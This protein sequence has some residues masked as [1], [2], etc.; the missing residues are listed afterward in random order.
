MVNYFEMKLAF[1]K[2]FGRKSTSFKHAISDLTD[3]AGY[4]LYKRKFSL[5]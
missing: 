2:S 3:F 5:Q 1:S 4:F